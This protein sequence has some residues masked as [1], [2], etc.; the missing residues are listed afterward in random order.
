[1]KLADL[2]KQLQD[3]ARCAGEFADVTIVA[4]VTSE[5]SWSETN[6]FE[7][8]DVRYQGGSAVELRT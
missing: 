8:F 3:I 2:I 1:M 5:E 6:W 7:T 4:S